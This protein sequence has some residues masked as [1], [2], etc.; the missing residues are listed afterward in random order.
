[1]YVNNLN[2]T[3]PVPVCLVYPEC[4]WFQGQPLGIGKQ[5]EGSSR[6]GFSPALSIPLLPVVP[7]LGEGP[8]EMSPLCASVVYFFSS[9]LGSHVV[10]VSRVKLPCPRRRDNLTALFLFVFLPHLL[11]CSF[12]LELYC[13]CIKGGHPT[14]TS[15]ISELCPVVLSFCCTGRILW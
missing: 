10:E 1:M 2:T 3:C 7:G 9:C 15:L 11:R 14:I 8:G 6:R 4:I 13:R 5:F 12:V